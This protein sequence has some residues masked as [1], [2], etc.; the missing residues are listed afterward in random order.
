MPATDTLSVAGHAVRL[1]RHARATRLTLR[2]GPKGPVLTIPKRM[3]LR[4]AAEFL[5]RHQD[6]LVDKIADTPAQVIVGLGAQVP[7]AGQLLTIAPTPASRPRVDGTTLLVPGPAPKVAAAVR[8]FLIAQARQDLSAASKDYAAQINRRFGRIT[9]RD[10]RSR[11]GSC[12]SRGDLNYSWRLIMAPA[13]VLDYVAAHEVAHLAQMNHSQRFWS[14]VEDLCP[15]YPV[16]RDWLRANG[17]DL[18][19]YDFGP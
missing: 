9:L 2:V 15:D 16:Y 14:I 5:D 19:R 11:W 17:P 4:Q 6:W 12:T 3:T 7:L 18:H 8:K 10:T 1:R 13:E